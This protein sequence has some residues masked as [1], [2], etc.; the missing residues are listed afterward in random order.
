MPGIRAALLA[1]A[2]LLLCACGQSGGVRP[3]TG[4]GEHESLTAGTPT[5]AGSPVTWSISPIGAVFS[6][7]CFC[8]SYRVAIEAQNVNATNKIWTVTWTLGLELVDPEG[9]PDPTLSGSAAAVDAGCDNNGNGV[10][11][12]RV[13]QVNVYF[14]SSSSDFIWYHPDPGSAP[15]GHAAGVFHCEHMKQGPHGHQGLITVVVRH[16]ALECKALYKGTHSGMSTAAG[17]TGAPQCS[18]V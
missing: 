14:G 10:T 13:D 1:S 8:T 15:P 4:V 18:R 11:A 2:L 3:T 12:P 6:Q 9:A 17:Q 7:D 16:G 5:S